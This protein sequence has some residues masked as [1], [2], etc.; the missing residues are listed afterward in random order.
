MRVLKNVINGNHCK[1]SYGL[2]ESLLG[3][4][5]LRKADQKMKEEMLDLLKFIGLANFADTLAGEL[6]GGQRRLLAIGW[7]I[8]MKPKLLLL[9]EPGVGLSPVNID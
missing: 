3:V 8:A 1:S 4:S 7:A 2:V 5:R 9:D 6:S